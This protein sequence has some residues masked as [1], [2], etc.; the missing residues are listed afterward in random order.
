MGNLQGELDGIELQLSNER[1]L[2]EE[3]E[4][5]LAGLRDRQTAATELLANDGAS[6]ADKRTARTVLANCGAEIAR[7]EEQMIC[8]RKRLAG[9]AEKKKSFPL[10]KLREERRL[11]DLRNRCSPP[12]S[13]R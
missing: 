11:A 12:R 4:R 6:F 5:T 1:R 9:W 3:T 13:W 10:D 8:I 7:T 2:I